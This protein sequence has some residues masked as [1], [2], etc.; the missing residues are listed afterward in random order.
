[1]PRTLTVS[2]IND[3]DADD[4]SLTLLHRATVPADHRPNDYH[5]LERGGTM[6]V[7]IEDAGHGVIAGES[8]LDVRENDGAATYTLRLKSQPSGNVTVRPVSG[9]STHATVSGDLVFTVSNWKTPQT[10][11]VTGKGE[12]G[13]TATVTHTIH[14]SADTANYPT[15]LTGLPTV[16]VTLTDDTRPMLT[17][18]SITRTG[19]TITISNHAGSWHHKRTAPTAGSCS[20]AQTGNGSATLSDLTENT[21]YTW[22]AYSDSACVD[23]NKL[24]ET[25]FRTLAPP[26]TMTI[27]A[28]AASKPMG[29]DASFTITSAPAP[30]PG[31][32]VGYR[33]TD[34]PGRDFIPD[35][36]EGVDRFVQFRD[37]VTTRKLVIRTQADPGAVSGGDVTVTLFCDP[38][39]CTVGDPASAT[40]T[41]TVPVTPAGVTL[42]ENGGTAV[43]EGSGSDTYTVVLD[44]APSHDVTVTVTAPA[45]LAVDTDSVMAGSQNALTFT[46]TTWSTA[47]TVTVT[48]PDDGVDRPRAQAITHAAAS[49]DSAYNNV[50]IDPVEVELT[51]NDP[52][53]ATLSVPDAAATEGSSTE[54]AEIRLDLGRPLYAGEVLDVPLRF[55]GGAVGTDFFLLPATGPR[56]VSFPSGHSNSLVR[57]TG[58]AAGSATAATVALEA[59]TDSDATDK[60][61]TVSIPASSTGNA[62]KLTATGLD[63]GAAG[64]RMG[65]GRITLA[66]PAAARVIL[67][68]AALALT[69]LDAEDGEGA[70]TVVLDT[71]PGSGATITVTARS[72]DGGAAT[73][74]PNAAMRFTGG[75]SGTWNVPQAVTV[76]A[77]NDGDVADESLS[78]SHALGGAAD[79]PYDGVA[80]GAV[81]V[82]VADAGHGV[83]A[84]AVELDVRG[85]G[86][87]ATYTLRLKSAPGGTVTVT[88]ASGDDAHAT[89]S[90]AVSFDDTDWRTP[91]AV[92]V[93]ARGGAGD[94]ATITHAVTASTSAAYP[95]TLTGLPEVE[96]TV[97][98]G[99]G[100][101]GGGGSGGGGGGSGGS[102]AE[103]RVLDA[104][105]AVEGSP[106]RF[107]V[108]LEAPARRRLDLLASTS[109]GTA[110]DGD[111]YLGLDARP[112][113][114]PEGASE[115]W[116]EVPTARDAD[117]GEGEEWLTLTLSAAPGSA[118]AS[119]VRREARGTIL[120]GP[121]PAAAVPLFPADSEARRGFARVLDRGWRGGPVSVEAVD[122]GGAG[123]P[124]ATLRL[125]PRGAA[126]FNAR[127]LENGNPAKGLGPGTGAPTRGHW[128]LRL[129]GADAAAQAYLRAADGFVTPLG[130][131]LPVQDDG[132]LYAAFLN[133]GSNW[134]QVSLLRLFNP[135]DGPA[136]VTV[137]GTDDAGASPGTPVRLTVPAGEARTLAARELERGEAPGV[138][139]DGALGDGRGKWRLRVT[140]D[141]PVEAMSL[142][143]SPTGHLAN[144]SAATAPRTGN[145][146]GTAT[147]LA[148]LLPP[149]SDPH[150][151][152]GFLRVVN[153]GAG[154]AEARIAA[155]DDAGRA[156]PALTLTVGAG[157]AVQLNSHDLE[158]GAPGKGLPL[159]TGPGEGSWRLEVT[160]PSAVSVTAHLRH[161]EDGFVTGMNALAPL[162]DGAHAVDFLNPGSNGRQ[163]SVLRLANPGAEDALAR[164]TGV[165]DAGA[166]G[167]PVTVTVPAFRALA[168]ASAELEAGAA[169]PDGA[170]PDAAIE[171]ALGDGAGKW[172]LRVEA[173]RPIHVMSL[174]RSPTGHLAN[175]SAGLGDGGDQAEAAEGA[176]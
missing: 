116:V 84:S 50:S 3:G 165:D 154:D 76:T 123:A 9:D 152:Q 114:V 125:R 19:A 34:A 118:P 134:R 83:I 168:L 32:T 109:P 39:E 99:G 121:P 62:P 72:G 95:T 60:T 4:E 90:A 132:S 68:P 38:A 15:G 1:E 14:A 43:T 37:A 33:L 66:E 133:P 111:D 131:T 175:L 142:L 117:A 129:S 172:R 5:L 23:A 67:A 48:A 85:G 45:G 13:D 155:R 54:T 144:L 51:D 97:A 137:E 88:P 29:T 2:A 17:A 124:A 106:L 86:G 89:A 148:P 47:R 141:R 71:D 93:T 27:A 16:A 12:S 25:S 113:A 80:P 36:I 42:T 41:V 149:A 70:Y 58:S 78:V 18:G 174:L 49:A 74:S 100:G 57:F 176:P 143:E 98:A 157:R 56:G 77:V 7:T 138:D 146:D 145:G 87:T 110:A 96:V 21:A 130:G 11:T 122:D 166:P 63:G 59:A 167:G 65:N 140:S 20:T 102:S 40:V 139:L 55:A 91:K 22:A 107:R 28:D 61:V 94:T 119:V 30:A 115:A 169:D 53:A 161:L 81:A 164:I 150:R 52:T 64:S 104:E 82:A 108:T 103:V 44:T 156:Y 162:R 10:V 112:V 101:T 126:H 153:R 31:A 6:T 120:D 135:G 26:T 159:G 173:D 128:R 73:V 24:A 105:A 75:G 163:V 127:D 171:G 46:P 136:R 151:R 158:A 8:A 160:A 35:S 69:E 170:A 79:T 147:T 92:T